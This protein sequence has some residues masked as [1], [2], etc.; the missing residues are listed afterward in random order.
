L[1][2]CEKLYTQR[3]NNMN[4]FGVSVKT[5]ITNSNKAHF[6]LSQKGLIISEFPTMPNQGFLLP[7]KGLI[8]PNLS[9]DVAE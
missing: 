3:T 9:L 6:W 2:R 1:E 5:K 4:V 7:N 8:L